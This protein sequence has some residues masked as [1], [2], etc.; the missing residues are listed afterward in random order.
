MAASCSKKGES[1]NELEKLG[2][3]VCKSSPAAWAHI[4][5]RILE[6]F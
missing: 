3:D 6:F 5:F 2:K 1:L 4:N